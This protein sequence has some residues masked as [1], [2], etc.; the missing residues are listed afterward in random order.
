VELLALLTNNQLR[1]AITRC[2]SAGTFP[3]RIERLQDFLVD[4]DPLDKAE[5][6]EVDP[7]VRVREPP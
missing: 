5:E 2:L 6:I 4:K 1:S 3:N 7:V